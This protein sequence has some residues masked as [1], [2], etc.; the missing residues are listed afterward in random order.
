MAV[1][2]SKGPSI[3]PR[4]VLAPSPAGSGA[5]S[6]PELAGSPGAVTSIVTSRE[7]VLPPRPKPGRKPSADTPALKRKAQNRAAQRAFRERRATRVQELEQKLLEVEKEKELKEIGLVN[8]INK[9]KFE[10]QFLIKSMNQLRLEFSSLK[11]SVS[12]PAPS[13][14]TSTYVQPIA[15]LAAA[16]PCE[17]SVN[18]SKPENLRNAE[19]EINQTAQSLLSFAKSLPAAQTGGTPNLHLLVHSVQQI[20]PAPS[21]D[22]PRVSISKSRSTSSILRDMNSYREVK[23]S[24]DDDCGICI[25]D[26]CLC[27]DVGLKTA[28]SMEETYKSFK[29]L[30]AVSLKR[31][32]SSQETD[33]TT[34]FSS[35]KM[36]DLKRLRN[37]SKK[38]SDSLLIK[39]EPNESIEF[40]ENSPVENCGFCSDDTP[41]VCREAALEAARLSR[42]LSDK[43]FDSG[44]GEDHDDDE[45][46]DESHPTALPPLQLNSKSTVRKTS[47]PVLHPGPSLEIREFSNATA[48]TSSNTPI[49]ESKEESLGCTGNPGTCS[50]CQLDPMSTL[51]CTTVAS[52]AAMQKRGDEGSSKNVAERHNAELS[53]KLLPSTPQPDSQPLASSSGIF[54]PCADAYKTLSRHKR[55]NS[56]DFSNLVGRLTTRGM[57]VEVQSVANIIRELDRKAYD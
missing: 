24:Q 9:L 6:S 2:A 20:L 27:V 12:S 56:V 45:D 48:V 15:L 53:A 5:A 16:S 37:A 1:A 31:K 14:N 11:S 34:M 50:Q 44:D 10:N 25:K 35:K 49:A 21:T 57:Q 8:T 46:E 13:P 39:K 36:P 52:K 30:A 40:N 19:A 32:N 38:P 41:C 43:L 23:D 47:L 26:L 54:I 18:L 55:F 29:P 28:P 4:A 33:F 7:W 3:A 42:S 51:F 17:P 22:S